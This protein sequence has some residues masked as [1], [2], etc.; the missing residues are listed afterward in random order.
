M[1]Y[2][3]RISQEKI[4][5][6]RSCILNWFKENGRHFPW[7]NKSS[8]NY[9]KTI[10]EVLLQRTKAETVAKFYS[11]FIT[12]Y[13]SWKKLADATLDDLVEALTPIGLQKQRA[14]RLFALAQE[15]KKRKGRL[16]KAREEIEDIPMFG[17]YITNAIMLL[18]YGK[19][20]PLL[21]VNM[22]RV[23]ERF[24]GS[25]KMS[26][27]R[28]DSYLQDLSYK[29]VDHKEPTIINWAILD[30]AALIC[31]AREPICKICHINTGCKFYKKK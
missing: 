12:K 19:P 30:F 23:L 5:Y 1:G 29:I 7:R 10:S 26:D 21:D 14:K 25:R 8:T 20:F 15:M 16:P 24:F 18:V 13:P 11:S 2:K 6:F 31:K 27:I 17:Q 22:S 3:K 9:K 4:E 28:Y